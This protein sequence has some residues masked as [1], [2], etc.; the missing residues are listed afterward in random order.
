MENV[1]KIALWTGIVFTGLC[2]IVLLGGGKIV[3]GS[4]LVTLTF[5]MLLPAWRR[6]PL[7]GRA[8]LICVL[9]ALVC[10]NIST[11]EIPDPSNDMV[12]VCSTDEDVS[13]PST[14]FKFLD[15]VML[16]FNGFTAQAEFS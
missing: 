7:W 12:T 8:G 3:S 11:T 9:F 2:G 4:T 14:G 6:I 5:V 10:W 16:I 15:Q 13:V 1:K